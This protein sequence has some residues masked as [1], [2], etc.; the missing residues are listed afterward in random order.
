VKRIPWISLLLLLASYTTFSWFLY[1]ATATWTVWLAAL[2]F[3]LGQ[4]LLLTT[5]SS[6]FRFFMGNWLKSDIGY[7]SIVLLG[8]LSL[9]FILVWSHV[10]EYLL[11]VIGSEVLSRLELQRSRF[12]NWQSLGIL[13]VVSIAGL[14]IGW[15]AH[16]FFQA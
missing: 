13:T 1:D 15:T 10:F 6:G 4:A 3:A 9:A 14:S 12:N 11:V 8:A 5:F 2:L 16:T 7:F